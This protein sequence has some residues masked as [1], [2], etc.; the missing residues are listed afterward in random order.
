MRGALQRLGLCARIW[1]HQKALTR[2]QAERRRMS[3][4]L[5]RHFDELCDMQCR[6]LKKTGVAGH[7]NLETAITH[8]GFAIEDYR[9]DDV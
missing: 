5:R 2:R 8:L 4:L 3:R 6:V 1:R 7:R 9:R